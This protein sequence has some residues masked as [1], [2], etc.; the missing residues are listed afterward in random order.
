M[1]PQLKELRD[2]IGHP[3][4][5]EILESGDSTRA[6]KIR[7]L[8]QL[9]EKKNANG[10]IYPSTLW[11][12]VCGDTGLVKKIQGRGMLGEVEH[13]RDGTTNLSRVS[14]IVTSLTR[15]GNEII[16]EAEILNTPSGMIIQELLSKGVPIGIS[17]RGRGTSR[18]VGDQEMVDESTYQL[19]TFDIVY[20]PSTPGAFPALQESVLSDAY[21]SS[22]TMS[23]KITE[24]KRLEVQ[25]SDILRADLTESA[26][27][28]D[29]F[30]HAV[31]ADTNVDYI[32]DALSEDEKAENAMLIESTRSKVMQS[33]QKAA[34][35]MEA[36]QE[37]KSSD[38]DRRMANLKAGLVPL[39]ESNGA[40]FSTSVQAQ[41]SG[42]ALEAKEVLS[43]LSEERDY[44]RAR[45]E[46]SKDLGES[47]DEEIHRRYQA[48]ITLG[49]TLR[50]NLEEALSILNDLRLD[51]DALE[52]R[53]TAAHSMLERVAERQERSQLIRRIGEAVEQYPDLA[54][55]RKAL[56]EC[57]SMDTLEERLAEFIDAFG[58][59]E[60]GADATNESEDDDG[61]VIL[62]S[63]VSLSG[64]RNEGVSSDRATQDDEDADLPASGQILT[65]S[66]QDLRRK[67]SRLSEPADPAVSLTA[68]ALKSL[69]YK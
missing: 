22:A 5:M 64:A 23:D 3:V 43:D 49:E 52:E 17:S 27:I 13:P 34:G 69:G 45:Y 24:L 40:E 12:R 39:A 54:R 42:L 18:M 57:D 6:M 15:K 66:Q 50:V 30:R 7:G 16:G 59:S 33:R 53:Y 61:T 36:L 32:V 65:E 48:S 21:K 4:Q 38:T 19:D 60:A 10:R 2:S 37:V 29:S 8:F 31:E 58:Y 68:S 51:H 44:W 55:V 25:A 67:T 35:A 41:A 26:T 63:L 56:M 62:E 14:H 47:G 46:E 28:Y 1:T 9:A 20:K 11:E